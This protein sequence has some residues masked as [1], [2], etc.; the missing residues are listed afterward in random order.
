VREVQ[1]VKIRSVVWAVAL[2]A[3]AF[4]APAAG[5]DA[6]VLVFNESSYATNVDLDQLLHI[7]KGRTGDFLWFLRGG[8]AYLV[9]DPGVLAEGREILGPVR[10]LSREQEELSAR[11]RPFEEREEDLDRD[12]ERLEKR[13][14]RL[15][16]RDDRAS[17]E[18]RDR[19][20]AL[21]RELDEKQEAVRADMRELEAEE[22]RVDERERELEAEADARLERLIEDALR[23]GLAR[24]VR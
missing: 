5:R 12:E 16:G 3:I 4:E 7:R 19:L 10:A 20:D 1:T 6:H 15:E 2:G 18:Q 23:R 9:T 24:R 8:R 21:R 14:E 17:E 22:R 11:L 13:F